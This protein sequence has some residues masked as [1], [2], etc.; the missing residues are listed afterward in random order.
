MVLFP[1][2]KDISQTTALPAEVVPQ[3]LAVAVVLAL[4]TALPPA[5]QAGRLKIVDA[6]ARR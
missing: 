3:G 4:A 1:A 6:L 2:I 5:F